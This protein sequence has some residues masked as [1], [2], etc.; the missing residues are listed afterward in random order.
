[1]NEPSGI[2]YLEVVDEDNQVVGNSS[3][4]EIHEKGLRHRSVHIF[5]FNTKGELYLQKRSTHKDQ[6]PEYWDTSAA[7]HTD[8]GES[9]IE[10]AQRELLEELGLEVKLTEVLQYPACLE[11]GWEFVTLFT[12][13]T[14]DPIHLDLEEATTGDY[15]TPDQLIQLLADPHQKV[16]PGFRLLHSL[17]QSKYSEKPD[18]PT[19]IT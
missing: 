8:P 16:A 17:Y 6:Y 3:R 4:K 18:H 7:G 10:A 19:K 9:P 5:I 13:R 12:A 15:F 1:M 14:D 11:T 2:E